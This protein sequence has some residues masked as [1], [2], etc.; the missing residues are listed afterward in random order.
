MCTTQHVLEPGHSGGRRR[1]AV[2]QA[3]FVASCIPRAG[4]RQVTTL[5]DYP[6]RGPE[7]ADGV[8]SGAVS[9]AV[10][11]RATSGWRSALIRGYRVFAVVLAAA[12]VPRVLAIVGY[13]PAVLFRKGTL[14]YLWHAPPV[15]ERDQSQR[16]L[17]VPAGTAPL[18][19]VRSRGG[20]AAA[21]GAGG[22]RHGVRRAEPSARHSAMPFICLAAALAFR[23]PRPEKLARTA[24]ARFPGHG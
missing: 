20:L 1:G 13:Q 5:E 6:G 23:K 21:D 15:P 11:W 22:R 9:P 8:G 7:G 24:P 16:L 18:P 2:G 14:D 19:P 4:G 12:G 10:G 17:L 3:A